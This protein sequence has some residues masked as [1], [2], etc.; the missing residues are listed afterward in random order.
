MNFKIKCEIQRYF[1]MV[2]KLKT[3]LSV[4]LADWLLDILVGEFENYSIWRTK[5]V[6]DQVS[7]GTA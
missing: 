4:F 5:K 1:I 6:N 2:E 7:M 3:F